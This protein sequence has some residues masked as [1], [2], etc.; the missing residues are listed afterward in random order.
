M[1]IGLGLASGLLVLVGAVVGL[2]LW[3]LS[4]FVDQ[5]HVELEQNPVIQQHLGELHEL[6][7]DWLG[8]GEQE[9]ENVFVF[10]ATGA[11]GTGTV[12]AECITVSADREE[13]T[14]G[15]L[16]LSSGESIPLV[17]PDDGAP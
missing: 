8:T 17:P 5:V 13:I 16:Q 12:I 14:W 9:G 11:R 15:Q 7:L 10:E 6:E 2:T 1:A 4:M 3:G